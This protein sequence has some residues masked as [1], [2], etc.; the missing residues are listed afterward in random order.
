MAKKPDETKVE[1]GQDSPFSED[2]GKGSEESPSCSVNTEEV[3]EPEVIEDE[4]SDDEVQNLKAALAASNDKYMRLSAEWDNFR[5]RSAQEY[6]SSKIRATEK[7]IEALLPVIDDLERACQAAENTNPEGEFKAFTQG[8]EAV[9]DKLVQTLETKAKLVVIDPIDEA[10]DALKH[11]AVGQ[12]ENKEV[13][14]ETV[15]N[16]LQKGYEL[17]GYVIRPAMVQITTGGPKRPSEDE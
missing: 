10:F 7:L 8:V 6:E 4:P 2:T 15:C 17:G 11:Q 1:P 3:L 5:K 16:V 12:V 13:F 14:D 9:H